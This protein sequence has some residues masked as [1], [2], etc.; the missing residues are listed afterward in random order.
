MKTLAIT[1][2]LLAG[3]TTAA[4]GLEGPV[5]PREGRQPLR[6]EQTEPIPFP[7]SLL[8]RGILS[9]EARV[10]VSV[11]TAGVLTDVLVIGYSHVEFADA[12]VRAVRR[13]R[14][15][16]IRIDGQPV[17]SQVELAINFEAQGVVLSISP[18][19]D[20]AAYRLSFL[21]S[22]GYGPCSLQELDAI[23]LPLEFTAPRYADELRQ[24]GITGAAIVEFYIDETGAVR[25]ASLKS[26]DFWELGNLAVAA[27]QQWK[28][29][30]PTSHGKPVL[31][32]L[33][34]TFN[35]GMTKS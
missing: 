24:R 3:A 31:V 33:R 9:G 32:K 19:T 34:Q 22:E 7:Q 4:M 15:E 27:V 25:M 1:F 35:F 2:L 23:P 26:A 28:F 10:I 6:F 29:A 11:D 13:W 12:T 30:P 17:P 14:Y 8:N 5:Q 20:L 18:G 21:R 16:P